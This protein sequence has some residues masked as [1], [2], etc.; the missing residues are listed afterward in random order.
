[1]IVYLVLTSF[2]FFINTH[3]TVDETKQEGRA[4]QY[5]QVRCK[6]GHDEPGRIL[7]AVRCNQKVDAE[8]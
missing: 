8:K 6:K 4:D 5:N 1:M 3:H 7:K 2:H